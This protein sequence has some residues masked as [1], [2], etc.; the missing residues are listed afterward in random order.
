MDQEHHAEPHLGGIDVLSALLDLL[1][2]LA[3]HTLISQC[4]SSPRS[5]NGYQK[6]S[7]KPDRK[8]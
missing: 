6:L 4:F 8:G 2:I 1:I 3:Q 5:I 7:G